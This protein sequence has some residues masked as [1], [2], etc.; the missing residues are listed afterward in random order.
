MQTVTS[1]EKTDFQ[2]PTTYEEV[3]PQW[4]IDLH[5]GCPMTKHQIISPL[6]SSS[7]V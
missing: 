3:V 6:G 1:A 2:V 4:M 7:L 5:N